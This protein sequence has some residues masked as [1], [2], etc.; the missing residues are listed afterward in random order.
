MLPCYSASPLVASANV[1][2]LTFH[3]PKQIT[4]EPSVKGRGELVQPWWVGTAC[5]HA[6]GMEIR[7]GEKLGSSLQIITAVLLIASSFPLVGVGLS[8]S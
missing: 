3:W 4:V 6:K 5:L 2:L 1:V 7:R 8:C